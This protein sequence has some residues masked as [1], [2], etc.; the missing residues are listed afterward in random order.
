MGPGFALGFGRGEA[1]VKGCSI[2]LGQIKQ[3]VGAV[4]E[5]SF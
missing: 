2:H 3:Y 5:N 1:E 4:E